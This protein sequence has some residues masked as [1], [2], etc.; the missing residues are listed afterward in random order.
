VI[1]PATAA[2]LPRIVEIHEACWL[3][4]YPAP[5][6]GVGVEEIRSLIDPDAGRRLADWQERLAD[7]AT[8]VWV[9]RDGGEVVG[10]AGARPPWLEYLHVRPGHQG[11]G[12]GTRLLRTALDWLGPGELR[13]VV[14]E[15]NERATALYRRYGFEVVGVLPGSEATFANGATMRDVVMVRPAG[16][17]P[18]PGP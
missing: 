17:G 7:P 16:G 6:R 2:D 8:R 11:R 9:A 18:R 12:I 4:A 3:T 15:H 1:G 13:I 14:V 10:F 5:E